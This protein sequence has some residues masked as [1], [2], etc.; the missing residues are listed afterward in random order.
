MSFEITENTL[1]DYK[2]AI[3][4]IEPVPD[5]HSD[6]RDFALRSVGLLNA[7]AC[8]IEA[9]LARGSFESVA[10]AYW[11]SAY[12][13]GLSGCAGMSMTERAQSLGVERATISK[14]AVAFCSANNL[15]P[16]PYMKNSGASESYCKARLESIT[17]SNGATPR[18]RANRSSRCR[19]CRHE[20][21]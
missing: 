17:R 10:V 19:N 3:D 14:A 7:M 6:L 16:S 8:T 1:V 15:E 2:C 20:R 12:A 11:S 18:P 9:G 13:L 4:E 21:K 5:R